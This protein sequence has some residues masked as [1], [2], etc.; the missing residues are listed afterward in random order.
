MAYEKQ[1]ILSDSSGIGSPRSR[2]GSDEGSLPG[3]EM[4]TF[5]LCPHKVEGARELSGVPHKGY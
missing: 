2:W 1:T 4:A 3:S 5:S